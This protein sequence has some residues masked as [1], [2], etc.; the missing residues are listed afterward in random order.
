MF[1]TSVMTE[2]GWVGIQL[3]IVI[4]PSGC[5]FKCNR[6]LPTIVQLSV[7]LCNMTKLESKTYHTCHL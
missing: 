3:L 5:L 6:H 4:F 7:C 2:A 1:I